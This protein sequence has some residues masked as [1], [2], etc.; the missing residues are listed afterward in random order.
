MAVD[1][2]ILDKENDKNIV[3]FFNKISQ[4]WESCL[5]LNKNTS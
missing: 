5:S 1:H 4:L 2:K 3:Y